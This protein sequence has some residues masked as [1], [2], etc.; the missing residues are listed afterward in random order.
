M[1][2]P[3]VTH[4][5]I[6]LHTLNAPWHTTSYVDFTASVPPRTWSWSWGSTRTQNLRTNAWGLPDKS[7]RMFAGL[8]MHAELTRLTDG[9][10]A[11]WRT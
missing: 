2:E 8:W 11:I 9:V 6:T 3:K 5:H 7:Q 10:A 4:H 1:L